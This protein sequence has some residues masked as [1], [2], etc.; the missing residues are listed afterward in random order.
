MSHE[1]WD[2]I[3]HWGYLA[4]FVGVM[5]EGEIFLIVVGIATAVGLLHYPLVILASGLGAVLH[6]NTVFTISRIAGEKILLK[7][8]SWNE[9]VNKSLSLLD[10][11]DYWAILSI[12]FLYG[13]RTIT[14]FVVGISKIKRLK[15]FAFDFLS[16]FVWSFIYITIGYFSGHAVLRA[17][18]HFH[19]GKWIKEHEFISFVILLFIS[20]IVFCIFKIVKRTKRN[21]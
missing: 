12:R 2:M 9:K 21:K 13:L 4:V 10:K 11:Y 1:F 20:T 8:P 19:L 18:S 3:V 17:F 16:S 7:R 14:I 5:I 15:F 6:D